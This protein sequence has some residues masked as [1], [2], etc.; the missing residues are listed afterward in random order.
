MKRKK[1]I[2]DLDRRL[3]ILAMKD[4][5]HIMKELC[6]IEVYNRFNAWTPLKLV[7]LSYFVGPF[8]RIVGNL[9]EKY[10][11]NLFIA[12]IDTFAGSG[13]NELE[14]H[15]TV[16]SPIAAIDSAN[17]TDH[18]FDMMYFADKNK[19]FLDAL[20]RRLKLLEKYEEYRWL[21]GRYKIMPGEANETLPSIVE[22]ISEKKYKNCL[23]FI[24]PYKWEIKMDTLSRLLE[25]IWG[26]VLITHQ[27]MLTAKEIGKFK[28]DQLTDDTANKIADYLGISTSDLPKFDT[29]E[30][31]KNLYI[32][33]IRKH[34]NYVK[35]W[36]VRSDIGYK[37]YIIFASSKK[38]PSWAGVIESLTGFEIFTGNIVKYC[39]ERMA[40]RAPRITDF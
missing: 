11:G 3:N 29:E 7:A 14:G 16:G 39:F 13:I 22:E 19:D 28:K 36:P 23:A 30:K 32:S 34:K 18:K 35:A 37:Y 12:Y 8:L 31:V 38:N 2:E 40:G 27:A 24:D 10:H 33:K 15:Y 17:T 21:S 5:P 4:R 6:Q 25:E 1:E 20:Y 26:D 9:K